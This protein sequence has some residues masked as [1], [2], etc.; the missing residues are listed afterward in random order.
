M[1]YSRW[2]ELYATSP[3]GKAMFVCRMCGH[4]TPAPSKN[5]PSLPEVGP[6]KTAFSCLVLEEIA[7]ALADTNAGTDPDLLLHISPSGD[8]QLHHLVWGHVRLDKFIPVVLQRKGEDKENET[9][10]R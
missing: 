8:P 2:I 4:K 7:G 1:T 9:S 3:S 5:C 6:Y 10:S